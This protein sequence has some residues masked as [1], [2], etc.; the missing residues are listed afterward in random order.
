M[1]EAVNGLLGLV[2]RELAAL[3]GELVVVRVEVARQKERV[4]MMDERNR[5]LENELRRALSVVEE[6]SLATAAV[7]EEKGREVA[8][9]KGDL[10]RINAEMAVVNGNLTAVTGKVT[11]MKGEVNALK[12]EVNAVKGEV[13]AVK[14][15]V[16]AVNGEVNT[17]KGELI[18]VKGKVGA[19]K[20]DVN[21]VRG[22][23]NAVKRGVSVVTGEV[24]AVKAEVAEHKQSTT[25]QLEEAERR[26]VAEMREMRGQV[27]E[28]EWKLA[29][30]K[31]EL[32][33][34][35]NARMKVD[36]D[37]QIRQSEG[38]QKTAW[39]QLKL[40]SRETDLLGLSDGH[41]STIMH[42]K[43]IDL[44]SS[45]GFSA[46]GIKHLYR[47][48]RLDTLSL[49][50]TDVSDS[51]LEGIGSLTSLRN[52]MLDDTKVTDAGLSHLTALSSLEVLSLST[53]KG[54]TNTGMVHV[55]RLTG[56]KRLDLDCTAVTD[57]GLQQLTA[58]TKLTSLR[59]PNGVFVRNDDV[60]RWIRR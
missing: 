11:A 39:E 23:V 16:N 29:A 53:C 37:L 30:V 60:R 14:G 56:L 2:R 38:D 5:D 20:G 40:Q 31:K 44:S 32:D 52:L 19:M 43:S 22:G 8:A 12:W 51:V 55:G 35:K 18:A 7:M 42:L 54:V 48:P 1:S 57:D 33:A 4:L 26:R 3:R 13:N 9:V 6:K 34:H 49:E 47:L 41:V 36:V 10:I 17:V 58:L 46:E 15:E 59:S 28:R 45:S 25:L 24:N 50:R 27:K 21:A